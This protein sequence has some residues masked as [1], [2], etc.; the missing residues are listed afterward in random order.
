MMAGIQMHYKMRHKNR[1]FSLSPESGV[2]LWWR[3]ATPH[4]FQFAELEN[5]R[6]R[7]KLM[8]QKYHEGV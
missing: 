6:R 2:I 5:Y 4:R 8:E 1:A 7:Q 3:L